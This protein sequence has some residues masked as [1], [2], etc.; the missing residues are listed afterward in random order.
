[1]LL[2]AGAYTEKKTTGKNFNTNV[3]HSLSLNP[4]TDET[5]RTSMEINVQSHHITKTDSGRNHLLHRH[6]PILTVRLHRCKM[7]QFSPF[8]SAAVPQK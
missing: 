2:P 5:P 1:M 7:Y 6:L 3:Q 8:Y 4:K